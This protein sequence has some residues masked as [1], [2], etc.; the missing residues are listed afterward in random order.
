MISPS[1]ALCLEQK[2]L[3]A[4]LLLGV[5]DLSKFPDLNIFSLYSFR[6]LSMT[7]KLRYGKLNELLKLLRYANMLSMTSLLPLPCIGMINNSFCVNL[8]A[9]RIDEGKI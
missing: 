5:L 9:G 6:R 4:H 1:T 8:C 3:L 7:R 2:I